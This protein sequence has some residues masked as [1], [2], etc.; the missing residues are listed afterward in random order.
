ME[1]FY[2]DFFDVK[3]H[4]KFF[5]RAN[6]TSSKFCADNTGRV[7]TLESNQKRSEK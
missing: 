5:N 1:V 4:P 7:P 3:N 2:H 6:Q